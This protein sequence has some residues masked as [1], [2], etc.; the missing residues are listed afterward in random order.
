MIIANR[1]LAFKTPFS[2]GM[3]VVAPHGWA[4]SSN[5]VFLRGPY[6]PWTISSIVPFLANIFFFSLFNFT[7]QISKIEMPLKMGLFSLIR[8]QE[9]SPRLR[10]EEGLLS[11]TQD[12]LLIFILSHCMESQEKVQ[13]CLASDL[14][15]LIIEDWAKMRLRSK[16]ATFECISMLCLQEESCPKL[17]N[18]VC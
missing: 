6:N 10:V 16:D 2:W 3:W 8:P 12:A 18:P 14:K 13:H 1:E 15:K 11:I 7:P 9:P 4:Q 5:G 17:Y